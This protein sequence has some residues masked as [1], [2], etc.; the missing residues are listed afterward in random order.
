VPPTLDDWFD[1]ARGIK[2]FYESPE[3]LQRQ[4]GDFEVPEL[5]NWLYHWREE[6]HDL[7][8]IRQAIR[9]D[10]GGEWRHKHPD[11]DES[12]IIDLPVE[13]EP[14]D[15]I[16]VSMRVIPVTDASS[17]EFLNRGYSY[18][19]AAFVVGSHAYVFVGHKDLHPRFF[20]VDLINATVVPLGPRT[21]FTSEGEG[22]Y[23]DDTGHVYILDGSRLM[24]TSPLDQ[25]AA[26]VVFD[27]S[28]MPGIPAGCDLW[29]PHS[30]DDGRVHS[31]TVRD[32]QH[33][34]EGGR[35]PYIGTV[36]YRLGH[37]EFYP[38][39][40]KLDESQI[41]NTGRMLIIKETLD[42]GLS[43]RIIDLATRQT[44]VLRKADGAVGHSDCG[45]ML[46]IGE[47]SPP[48]GPEH[49]QCVKLDLSQPL[50][51]GRRME[52]FASW[53]VGHISYRNGRCLR[54]DEK[55]LS[56]VGM[57]GEGV[58]PIFEHGMVVK[59]ANNA[60][61]FQVF[62]NLDHSGRVAAFMS[63]DGGDRFDMFLAVL[64]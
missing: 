4:R 46:L 23:W 49:G 25:H 32:A 61:N 26:E 54:S 10:Q 5:A 20:D 37:K 40:G 41:D 44:Q 57:N 50:T 55:Y 33:P 12:P 52:L 53:N 22:M 31:A 13:N 28:E 11:A 21:G 38:A 42:D 30:S 34:E 15:P 27:I 8:W 47:W 64:P 39:V 48:A 24:R 51:P 1:V 9:D 35:Y 56:L 63:N 59:D 58:T 29:Q 14:T 3:G 2:A 19:P 6:G 7:N 60:Y 16:H 17:G 36:V 43:N 45:P 18:W 62:A